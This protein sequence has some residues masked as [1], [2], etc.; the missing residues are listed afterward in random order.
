MHIAMNPK[1]LG[2]RTS[3]HPLEIGMKNIHLSSY[4]HLI[5]LPGLQILFM[6]S[7]HSPFYR[8]GKANIFATYIQYC[9]FQNKS[10]QKKLLI[11]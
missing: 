6:L 11:S 1:T 8:K 4:P 10:R 3:L 2:H 7:N 5:T 9:N